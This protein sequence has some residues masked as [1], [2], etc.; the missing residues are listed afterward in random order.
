M[1]KHKDVDD[2]YLVNDGSLNGV[3]ESGS[4]SGA[5]IVQ[6]LSSC[7]ALAAK[8]QQHVVIEYGGCVQQYLGSDVLRLQCSQQQLL[9]RA[10][11]HRRRHAALLMKSCSEQLAEHVRLSGLG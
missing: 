9:R 1:E 5:L 10:W 6:T 7:L 3:G 8:V 2:Q 4:A 11:M